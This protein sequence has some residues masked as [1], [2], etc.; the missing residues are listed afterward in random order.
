LMVVVIIA[1][2][3]P[4]VEL[5]SDEKAGAWE[6]HVQLLR[7]PVVLLF[8]FGIFAYVGTEQGVAN[9]ISQFLSVYHGY[10]PQTTGASVVAYFWGLMTAGGVLGLVLVKLVDSRRVLVSFTLLAIISFTVALFGPGNWAL[11]AFPLVGF[12]ASVMYPI[13]VSL[14]LNSVKEHHGSFAGILMTGI[15][16]GAVVPLIVGWLGDHIGLRYGMLFLYLTLGYILSVGIWARP[17][18][19]NKVIRRKVGETV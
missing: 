11:I 8:F 5:K 16:G 2:K 13:I 17:I 19:T 4:K 10:D 6:V 3:F 15:A 12:F 14:A 18:V 9:W 7:N 1:S